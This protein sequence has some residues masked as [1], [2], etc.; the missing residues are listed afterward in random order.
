MEMSQ[1]NFQLSG[2]INLQGSVDADSVILVP[3]TFALGIDNFTC[4]GDFL[5]TLSGPRVTRVNVGF[6]RNGNR[7]DEIAAPF[8]G[9]DF[10]GVL[11]SIFGTQEVNV[12]GSIRDAVLESSNG[13]IFTI[14]AEDGFDAQ[15]NVR[16][17]VGRIMVGYLSGIRGAVENSNAS[18]AGAIR[19]IYL[20]PVYYT[21]QLDTDTVVLPRW[22]GPL[23]DDR[24]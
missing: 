1:Q 4:G 20:G 13:S 7:L 6:D 21:G 15:V 2:I 12:T 10:A 8:Q 14:L 18:V 11:S 9:S 3:S 19:A 17:V 24:P 5:G 22:H 23:V 16:L